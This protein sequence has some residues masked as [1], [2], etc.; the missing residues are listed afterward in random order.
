MIGKVYDLIWF[1]ILWHS[2]QVVGTY[3]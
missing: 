2:F 3:E 1:C